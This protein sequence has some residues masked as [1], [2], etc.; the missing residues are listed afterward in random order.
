MYASVYEREFWKKG[1][2]EGDPERYSVL[3]LLKYSLNKILQAKIATN[4]LRLSWRESVI[5][6]GKENSHNDV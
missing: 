3:K 6:H 1:Q 2:R 4:L 5:E